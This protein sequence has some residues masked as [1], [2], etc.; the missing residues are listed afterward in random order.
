MSHYRRD[1]IGCFVTSFNFEGL[2]LRIL[3]LRCSKYRMGINFTDVPNN[4]IYI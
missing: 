2:F 4:I 1:E 3:S